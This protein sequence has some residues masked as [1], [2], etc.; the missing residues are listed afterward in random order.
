VSKYIPR[1]RIKKL[2]GRKKEWNALQRRKIAKKCKELLPK[3]TT[4]SGVGAFF[5]SAFG[6]TSTLSVSLSSSK[7][8]EAES[9]M[10]E[11]EH[12][13]SEPVSDDDND[14]DNDDDDIDNDDNQQI[15]NSDSDDQGTVSE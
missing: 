14:N 4:S 5:G 11:S 6:T 12:D 8:N 2:I 3:Q 15:D 10:D 9:D 7:Q 1:E 13:G